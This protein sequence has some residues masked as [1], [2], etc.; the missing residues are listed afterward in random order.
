YLV[1]QVTSALRWQL[2][3]R[4]L[5]FPGTLGRFTA[6]YFIGTYFNLFLPTSVGG[7]VLRAWY[8]DRGSGRKVDALLSVFVDRLNGF[9]VLL[10]I[11]GVAAFFSPAVR[12]GLWGCEVPLAWV[13]WSLGAAAVAG[14]VG[15][16]VLSRRVIPTL[17]RRAGEGGSATALAV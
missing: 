8:V 2:L 14:L 3:A 17:A 10:G 13:A 1:A 7:D 16:V 5:G 6:I 11:A 4:P 15:A 9:L 12:V